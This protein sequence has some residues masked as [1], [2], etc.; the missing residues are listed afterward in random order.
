VTH[1][2][3]DAVAVADRV[4]VIEAGRVVQDAAV[5][6]VLTAPRSTWVAEL[7]GL[8]AWRGRVRDGLV[9][10]TG[11]GTVVAADT[12][13]GRDVLALL[14]PSAVALHRG[15][16]EGSPRNVLVGRVASTTFLAERV[17]VAIESTPPVT[18][19]V[20]VAAAAELGLGEGGD[21][22]ASFKATEVRLVDV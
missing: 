11:G 17:R 14:A 6:S 7:I 22:W 13:G 18:A 16:P 4:L 2:P 8:N 19:E 9:T 12:G 20:T 21:V 3:V 10:L 5:S 1:D 15:Q